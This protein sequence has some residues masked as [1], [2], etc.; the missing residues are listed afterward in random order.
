MSEIFFKIGNI[1]IYKYSICILLGVILAFL[2]IYFNNDNKIDKDN[3]LNII[4]YTLLF[5]IIG[6][7]LYYV[8]F[9]LDYYLNNLSEI[10]MI[11]KG[12]LAIH[13]GLIFG[14]IFLVLFTK[15]K[16]IDLLDILDMCMPGVL[17]AQSIGRWGNFFNHEAYGQAVTH[18]YLT[19]FHIPK[20]IIDN[21]YIDGVYRFP[22]FLVESILCLIGFIILEILYK[23]DKLK[24]GS[25]FSLYL[26]YY[27]IIR[28][29]IESQRQDSL[30]L[31]SLKMAQIIS[32]IFILCGIILLIIICKRKEGKKNGK[33]RNFK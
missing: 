16:K 26:I 24:K 30:M 8:L 17:L 4:C 7:R 10:I 6:A 32:I 11:N 28:F 12:G 23:K 5:G 20:F 2:I 3:L 29:F 27:G 15:K 33:R 19:K 9:N 21:M 31:N 18:N 14:L 13:G 1:T 22:C 25:I